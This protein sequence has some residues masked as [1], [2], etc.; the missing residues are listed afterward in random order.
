MA[1][2]YDYKTVSQ[3]A[4]G[5]WEAILSA[6]GIEMRKLNQNGHAHSATGMIAPT[7]LSVKVES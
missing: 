2:H 4:T 5:S 7:S 6:H 1:D 3:A